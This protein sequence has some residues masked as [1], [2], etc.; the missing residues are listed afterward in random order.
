ML[1]YVM[2]YFDYDILLYNLEYKRI[3]DKIIYV[4]YKASK[5]CK[6]L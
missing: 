1:C 6:K 2:L 3:I 5:R 4:A